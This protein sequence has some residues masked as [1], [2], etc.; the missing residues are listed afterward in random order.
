M[1]QLANG[2]K[3]MKSQPQGPETRRK[4]LDAAAALYARNGVA[5]TTVRDIAAA[6]GINAGSI[7]YHFSSKDDITQ[8][9]LDF[10]I[11]CVIDSVT[12]ALAK[13]DPDAGFLLRFRTAID[14]HIR[15][16]KEFED[17][18]IAHLRIFKQ[19]PDHVRERNVVFRDRYEVI[20]RDL[21][22]DG[23]RA[24]IIDPSV[25]I[26]AARLLLLGQMNW[27]IEWFVAGRDLSTEDLVDLIARLFLR[28]SMTTD[29]GEP[30]PGAPA[31]TAAS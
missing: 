29:H 15:A 31:P 20:W 4:L 28:G 5:A 13:L 22:D 30:G 24:G 6:C 17:Y 9:I 11:S 12:K 18:T 19:V 10:G 8:E 26:N 27:T 1:P 2:P 25:N 16:F 14:S 7:Y 23:V 3:G 21:L